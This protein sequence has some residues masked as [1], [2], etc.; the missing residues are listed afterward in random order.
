MNPLGEAIRTKAEA[1]EPPW[2]ARRLARSRIPLIGN[3]SVYLGVGLWG[4][5]GR[6]GQEGA[7]LTGESMAWVERDFPHSGVG[8]LLVQA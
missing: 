2:T 3:I 5:G 4:G 8:V 7:G 6:R 1:G